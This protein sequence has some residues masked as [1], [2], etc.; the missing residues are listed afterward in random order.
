MK[1]NLKEDKRMAKGNFS[2]YLKEGGGSGFSKGHTKF[3]DG[4]AVVDTQ[5]QI[6]ISDVLTGTGAGMEIPH[7]LNEEPDNV[8]FCSQ[9]T[10]DYAGAFTMEGVSKDSEKVV[11][12]VTAGLK[13][14]LLL[15]L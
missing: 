13:F 10:Q 4:K 8:L 14:Q 15:Q 3:G 5:G 6:W 2:T 9:G 7:D 11:V 1:R 12:N